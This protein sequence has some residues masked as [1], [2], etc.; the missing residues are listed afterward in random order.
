MFEIDPKKTKQLILINDEYF[1]LKCE[2]ENAFCKLDGTI[3]GN[4]YSLKMMRNRYPILAEILA[5]H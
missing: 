5:D 2:I 1:K 3:G 4:A